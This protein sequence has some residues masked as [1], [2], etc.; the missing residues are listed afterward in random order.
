MRTLTPLSGMPRH[1]SGNQYN[2]PAPLFTFAKN[3][4]KQGSKSKLW[5]E[6]PSV[7]GGPVMPHSL[8]NRPPE[9]IFFLTSILILTNVREP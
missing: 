4:C 9:G 7:G 5:P 6:M 2:P 3:I 8:R 1:G